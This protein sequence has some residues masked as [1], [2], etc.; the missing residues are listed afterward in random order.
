MLQQFK[1]YIQEFKLAEAEDQ[2]LVTVSGGIDSVVMLDL[3][4]RSGF[5]CQIAHCNFELRGE[6]SDGDEEFVKTLAVKY[7]L[8]FYCK[9]FQT[10]EFANENGISL[11]MAA[12]TLR[13]KW[14]E[15]I[16]G[17]QN[18][19]VI[20]TA[21][22]Q[23]DVLETFFINLTRGTGIKGMTGISNKVGRVIRPLLFASRNDIIAYAT[24]RKLQF[25]EDSSN[26]SEKYTRNKIRYKILPLL[27]EINPNFRSSL[28][29]TIRKLHD[30]SVI[31]ENEI[32]EQRKD[33]VRKEKQTHY[34]DLEKIKDLPNKN[35]YLYEFLTSFH[36]TQQQI[37]HIQEA[38]H[39]TP[40]KQFFSATNRLVKDRDFLIITP[41]QE[42]EVNRYYIEEGQDKIF[43]PVHLEFLAIENTSSLRIP[44]EKNIAC[45]D[46]D[47]LDFPLMIRK[48]QDGDYFQPFGMNHRKKLS[49]FLINEKLSL[50]E[51]ENLW[52]I[53][54]GEN[55]IWVMDHRI[56]E[57]YK[58]TD[59]TRQVLI[60]KHMKRT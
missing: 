27:E 33:I 50:V 49:D 20:A 34:I 4:T 15:D 14:F 45:L 54:S 57:R 32:N 19:N 23:D 60:I 59:S 39:S 29:E 35:T 28:I 42:K 26:V 5:S 7:G 52:L 9:H 10:K 6:E 18:L 3:F 48:W 58:I 43:E 36:F 24:S 40:G 21:H 53:L 38:I 56:D 17:T 11:Q 30:A 41:L 8:Q 51:K 46:Y 55:I 2:I 22:N 1:S 16:R 13:Y 31:Y 25:R 37:T 44:T 47:R 12:R